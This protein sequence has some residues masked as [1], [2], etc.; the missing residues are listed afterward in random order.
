ME[1]DLVVVC[2]QFRE[3]VEARGWS[4]FLDPLGGIERRKD[5]MVVEVTSH[6]LQGRRSVECS[7]GKRL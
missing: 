6:E 3:E 7:R 1:E 4:C 2:A 5:M